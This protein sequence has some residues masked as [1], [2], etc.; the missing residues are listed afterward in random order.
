MIVESR[1][2][3]IHLLKRP[4]MSGSIVWIDLLTLDK[5]TYSGNIVLGFN[6]ENNVYN[7]EKTRIFMILYL[8]IGRNNSDK[9]II[10]DDNIYVYDNSGKI[11][12]VY[13]KYV[14]ENKALFNAVDKTAIAQMVFLICGYDINI[15]DVNNGVLYDSHIDVDYIIGYYAKNTDLVYTNYDTL[16]EVDNKIDNVI[17]VDNKKSFLTNIKNKNYR[18]HEV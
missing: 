1:V 15:I 11:Q 4:F 12:E 9:N 6:Y 3:W 10:M 14:L 13:K 18:V 16:E 5:I 8:I 7:I 2:L 17:S